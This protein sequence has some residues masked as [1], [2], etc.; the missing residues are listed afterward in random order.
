MQPFWKDNAHNYPHFTVE[1]PCGLWDM[2]QRDFWEQVGTSWAA[3]KKCTSAN[4]CR[5]LICIVCKV[6]TNNFRFSISIKA[7]CRV[8]DC[9][10][11]DT[12]GKH[13]APPRPTFSSKGWER[14]QGKKESGSGVVRRM[15]TRD[16]NRTAASKLL[17]DCAHLH[18]LMH[19]SSA[20]L[21]HGAKHY[22]YFANANLC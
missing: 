17:L 6:C 19:H 16:V 14:K 4:A 10:G 8:R 9:L 11:M 5:I 20:S 15:W 21:R 1:S 3:W 18:V 13:C 12:T 7:L 22:I 2:Q